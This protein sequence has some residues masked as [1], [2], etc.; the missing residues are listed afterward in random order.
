[1]FESW[2]D[3]PADTKTKF[4][5]SKIKLHFLVDDG[6]DKEFIL[7]SAAKK[8]KDGRHQLFCQF[9]RWDP[10]LEKNLQNYPKYRGILKNDWAVFVQYRRKEKAQESRDGQTYSR[11][12]MYAVFHKKSDGSFVSEDAYNNNEKL[13]A[14]INDFMSENEAFQKVFGKEQPGYVRSIGLGVK[15]SHI[16]RSTRSTSSSAEM[17]N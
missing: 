1:M 12:E 15:P 5:D 6:R 10:T 11:R 16:N 8:W 3:I 13:Q 14:A 9:Y 4:Y 2:K 17:K 7:A